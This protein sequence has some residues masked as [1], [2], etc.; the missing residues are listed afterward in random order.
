MKKIY[1][2]LLP[3][4]FLISCVETVIVGTVVGGAAVLSEGSIFDLSQDGRIETA[5]RKSYKKSNDYECL[6]KVDIDVFN[7]NIMLSGYV[8]EARCKNLAVS[9]AKSVKPNLNIY[10]EIMVFGED[11]KLNSVNDSYIHSKIATR[12]K[13]SE[14]VKSSNYV[15][16]V[17]DSIVFVMG[18][19]RSESEFKKV[20]NIFRTGS[21]VKKVVSYIFIL[22]EPTSAKNNK[23]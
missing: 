11:Y 18:R 7:S 13:A 5:V 3:I 17:V 21:G 20:I 6:R 8:N 10:N 22:E 12:L 19:S 16:N 9:L 1:F 15:Y 14:G 2:L 23:K 4:L